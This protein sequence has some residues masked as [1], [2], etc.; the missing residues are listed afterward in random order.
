[1]DYDPVD[2]NGLF[3][4]NWPELTTSDSYPYT[5]TAIDA[6]YV[7]SP[8][9]VNEFTFGMDARHESNTPNPTEFAALNRAAIGA[10]IP[11]FDPQNN[12]NHLVPQA[13]FGGGSVPDAPAIKFSEVIP[14][15]AWAPTFT[16][17]D[18]LTVVRGTHTL[19]AGIYFTWNRFV[20]DS[21]SF[22]YQGSFDFSTNINNPF[23]AN[24]PFANAELGTYNS[25]QESRTRPVQDIR[26]LDL[27]W[28][29]QGTWKATRRLTL[30]CG[31][32]FSYFTPWNQANGLGLN[33]LPS[34]YNPAQ[35]VTLY[36][37]IINAQNQRVAENP[38]NGQL[39]PAG[40][41]GAIVPGSGN[42]SNGLI[43]AN[44]PG[45]PEGFMYNRGVQYGPRFGFAYAL[46]NDN[47]TVLRGGFGMS[48]SGHDTQSLIVGTVNSPCLKS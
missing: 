3:G 27:E 4:A 16:G 40:F 33:F 28:Y 18:S 5:V 38:L 47:K 6:S 31:L 36:T 24:Y 32:R 45:V 19:K 25:Y 29:V 41:I 46:T 39:F 22:P 43:S 11:Q 26:G 30:N 20:T 1:M 48:Y 2:D 17:S 13:S 34:D 42:P 44:A 10:N 7:F 21:G 14:Y 35:A 15:H 37:P 23:D 9:I 12:P 8:T